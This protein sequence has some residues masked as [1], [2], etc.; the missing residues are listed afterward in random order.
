MERLR[1]R[2]ITRMEVLHVLQYPDQVR[3]SRG[4][5]IAQGKVNGRELRVV[6]SA[7]RTYIKVVT[8]L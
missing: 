5:S 4:L 7:H 3:K 6:I 2:G 8:V 1:Q